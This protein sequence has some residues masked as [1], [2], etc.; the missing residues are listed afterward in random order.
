MALTT[1]NTDGITDGTIK[2]IDVKTGAA[3]AGS[4]IN[5]AFT[6]TS[7]IEFSSDNSTVAEGL[8]LNNTAGNTGDN[9][10]LA[11]STDSGNRKKSAISHV[12]EGPYGRGSLTFSIDGA[13]TGSLDIVADEKFRINYD[14]NIGIGSADPAQLLSLESSAPA[15]SIKDTA[16]YSANTNGGTI[17]FQG[18]DSASAVKAFAGIKGVSQSSDNGQL[19]LQ[20]RSGGTLYDRLTINASGQVLCTGLGS[21]ANGSIEVASSDPFIRIYDTNGAADKK[22]WDIR[23]IGS[24]THEQMAFR[25]LDDDNTNFLTKV[26]MWHNGNL[27]VVDGDLKVASGHGIDFS[28]TSDGSGTDSSELLADYE[29]GTWT[30]G[31]TVGTAGHVDNKYIKVGKLVHFW[32]R[33]YN[34]TDV[35]STAA[36][37]ITGLPYAVAVSCAA[38]SAFGK[39]VNQIEASTV[40]VTTS[41]QIQIYGMNATNNWTTVN[42]NDLATSNCE[43]YYTGSYYTT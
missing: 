7:S 12:D 37:T 10:S 26:K 1:V 14:G 31:V 16:S 18:L 32:G 2:D 25:T 43:I 36:L 20:T 38:G 5:P 9:V 3:I 13:D 28:A 40:Y 33:V 42:Y 11:F 21:A 23:V 6:T 22:K 29:E 41:E 39:E 35:S 34:P 30:G 4:K 19:K 27:E 15:I 17:Y 8:F 24:S